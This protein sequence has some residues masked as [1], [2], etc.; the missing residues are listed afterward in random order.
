MERGTHLE[1]HM[2]MRG[3][4]PGEAIVLI[5]RV[6]RNEV[7]DPDPDELS[8]SGVLVLEEDQYRLDPVIARLEND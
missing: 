8:G 2:L 4:P 1:I 3:D 6:V 5:G 7:Y